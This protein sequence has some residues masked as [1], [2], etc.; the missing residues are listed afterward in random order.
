M[1]GCDRYSTYCLACRKKIKTSGIEALNSSADDFAAK[2]KGVSEFTCKLMS[3]RIAK[4]NALRKAA[5]R[6]EDEMKALD[7]DLSK[8]INSLFKVDFVVQLYVLAC[9]IV[10]WGV[11]LLLQYMY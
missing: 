6:K 11:H 2:A 4:S 5:K 3:Q 7:S 1:F 10:L 9:I 8:A